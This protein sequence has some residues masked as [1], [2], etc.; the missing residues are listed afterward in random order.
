MTAFPTYAV[1][2][3]LHL[4]PQLQPGGHPH[5]ES[6]WTARIPII[7]S[8]LEARLWA[9]SQRGLYRHSRTAFRERAGSGCAGYH[10]TSLVMACYRSKHMIL[11]DCVGVSAAGQYAAQACS[12]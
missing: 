4:R 1:A 8:V 2:P 11:L 7:G 10:V 6:R 3:T 9:S 5:R 12:N